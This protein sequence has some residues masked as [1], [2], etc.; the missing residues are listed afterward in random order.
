MYSHPSPRLTLLFLVL[1]VFV[2]CVTSGVIVHA[3][4]ASA[5]AT[6]SS[7]Q[8]VFKGVDANFTNQLW[9]TDGTS[10]NTN[11]LTNITYYYNSLNL[12]TSLR[13]AIQQYSRVKMEVAF[14]ACG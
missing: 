12:L 10:A 8:V 9:V 6:S 5:T 13:L 7:T 2:S 3:A 11:E 1:I 14:T 4:L